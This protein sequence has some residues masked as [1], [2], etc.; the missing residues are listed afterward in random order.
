M[1][2]KAASPS[3]TCRAFDMAQTI[4]PKSEADVEQVIAWA[5][6]EN[7]RLNLVGR[8]S[9][10]RMAEP[11]ETPWRLDLSEISG[12]VDYQPE[13]LVLTARP[14]TALAEIEALLDQ[15]GQELAFEPPHL[16]RLYGQDNGG[17][18]GGVVSANLAGPRRF[19]SGAARDHFL[20]VRA[21]SGRGESFKSGGKVVKNVT[22]YDLCKLLAGAHGTLA[23]MTEVTIKVMPRAERTRT[24]LLIGMDATAGA[25]AMIA[26][27]GSAH[28][29]SGLTFAPA[30][31]AQALPGAIDRDLTAIRIEGPSPSVDA[32][33]DTLRNL[34]AAAPEH[35]VLDG[36]GSNAF[37]RAVRDLQPFQDRADGVLW[38]LSL[39]PAQGAVVAATLAPLLQADWLLDWGG[40]LLWLSL[41]ELHP[42]SESQVR[43]AAEAA[44]GHAM[45]YRAPE[46]LRRSVPVF[47]PQP[48]ALAALSRRVKESFDPKGLFNPGR[49]S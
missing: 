34:F 17:S 46:H 20:G 16:G 9:K 18:L 39:P 41:P 5:L 3:R 10:R 32:R 48:P 29:P 22:G 1:F 6:S 8:D 47:H 13:E 24:L 45:L 26:A 23:V 37:W 35:L 19:K 12:V 43:A 36:D 31:I 21:V 33:L 30:R 40:A 4:T 49:L 15:R 2:D 11:V 28:E 14:G 25:Q 27:A 7:A 44:G 42:V 38:R